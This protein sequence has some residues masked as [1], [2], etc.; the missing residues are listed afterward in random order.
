MRVLSMKIIPSK[1]PQTKTLSLSEFQAYTYRLSRTQYRL[2]LFLIDNRSA[3]TD[4]I[5]SGCGIGNVSWCA[6]ELNTKL[7]ANEDN[8]RVVHGIQVLNQINQKTLTRHWILVG[9]AAN[10][11][12]V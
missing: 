6:K 9:G 2:F 3:S 4:D 7:R 11:S 1:A 5:K 8:R 12:K 10:D